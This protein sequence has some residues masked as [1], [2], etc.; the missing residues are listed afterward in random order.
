MYQESHKA[1]D[2]S[3]KRVRVELVRDVENEPVAVTSGGNRNLADLSF[4]SPA[5]QTLYNNASTKGTTEAAQ[6][7]LEGYPAGMNVKSYE[8]YFNR[9]VNAGKLGTSFEGA[10][11]RNGHLKDYIPE[12][13]LRKFYDIGAKSGKSREQAA[14]KTVRR[15][16]KGQVHDRRTDKTEDPFLKLYE[17]IAEKTGHDVVLMDEDMEG[18]NG[19]FVR[20]AGQ[21]IFNTDSDA[22]YATIF[23]EAIGEFSEAWNTEE[24]KAFQDDLLEWYLSEYGEE[25]TDALVSR[26]QKL[27]R[28]VNPEESYREAANEMVN[29]ALAG[30]FRTEDGIRD[31]ANWLYG[32]K[33]QA[34][35]KSVLQKLADFIRNLI[36]KVKSYL[37]EEPPTEAARQTMDMHLDQAERLRRRILDIADLTTDGAFT[38]GAAVSVISTSAGSSD[39]A[40]AS[41]SSR[42]RVV[43][44]MVILPLLVPRSSS[45]CSSTSLVRSVST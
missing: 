36:A 31:F 4:E 19:E 18:I 24:M 11:K 34:E 2:G 17:K 42:V 28:T 25:R 9:F 44:S 20:S 7:Y 1:R 5:L 37:S 35:A 14:E 38:L 16:G 40:A 27:Y 22:R 6:L 39:W 8:M 26:Y 21:I 33:T 3:G 10:V 30:L 15:K 45:H 29:D 23:H 32:N 43:G 41:G 12:G 13:T